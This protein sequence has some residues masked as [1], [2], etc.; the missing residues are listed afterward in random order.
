VNPI[1]PRLTATRHLMQV[2]QRR[3][4][5]DQVLTS[6][7]APLVR[8]LVSGTLRHYYS[9]SAQVAAYLE[10]PLRQKDADLQWLLLLGSYQLLHTRIPSH[11]AVSETVAC[12]A[13]LKKPWA[14]GLVNAV[15]RAVSTSHD[16]PQ[17]TK[18]STTASTRFDHPDWFIEQAQIALPEHWQ[19]VLKANNTRAPMSIRVNAHKTTPDEYQQKLAAQNVDV[20]SGHANHPETLTLVTPVAQRTLPGFEQGE[21]AVQDAGAQLA[22]SLVGPLADA[23]VLD[24]C[25]APGGKAF[26]LLEQYPDINLLLLDNSPARINT[27]RSEAARLGHDQACDIKQA[28]ATELAWWDQQ[29]FDLVLLDA[30]CSGSGTVRRHPDIKLLRS[31]EDLPALAKLQSRLLGNLW[32]T[33][34]PGGTLLY[35]TCSLF[36]AENDEVVSHFLASSPDAKTVT[37]SMPEGVPMAHGW[38]TLPGEGGGDGFYYAKLTKHS[39][40]HSEQT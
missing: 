38:Q 4:T 16:T 1:N 36:V 27:L 3:L 23:R 9:L 29:P 12:T 17:A 34:A 19:S 20:Q 35:S 10:K 5:L 30:P 33:V 40:T 26:H 8:E 25:A 14:R 2:H 13:K 37:L 21:V 31:A 28:D 22:A 39:A 18:D 32:R 6:D 15:L 24:S 7:T 11:A